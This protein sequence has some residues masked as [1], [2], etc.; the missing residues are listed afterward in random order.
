MQ[1][2][3]QTFAQVI[4]GLRSQNLGGD[5]RGSEK[6]RALR[7]EIES[8]LTMIPLQDGVTI[9]PQEVLTRDISYTGIGLLQCTRFNQGQQFIL[10]LPRKGLKPVS[11]L[12]AAVFSSQPAKGL[13]IIGSEFL[14]ELSEDRMD[15]LESADDHLQKRIQNTILE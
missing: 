11:M 10:N 6:R 1:L 8:K 15:E 12:C 14:Q 9:H 4:E 2:S 13:F 7:I 3:T 5:G